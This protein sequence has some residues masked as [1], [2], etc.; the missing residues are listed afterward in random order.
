[1]SGQKTTTLKKN[2]SR[3]DREV[4]VEKIKTIAKEN[5]YRIEDDHKSNHV[6]AEHWSTS[7]KIRL[8][9]NDNN[10]QFVLNTEDDSVCKDILHQ[11]RDILGDNIDS[12]DVSGM[13]D[14]SF[15]IMQTQK[16]ISQRAFGEGG[17]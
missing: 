10:K 9:I 5:N 2:M 8:N 3:K 11:I 12:I 14:D 15:K 13:P 17:S 1:M 16:T 4:L 7:K 6:V